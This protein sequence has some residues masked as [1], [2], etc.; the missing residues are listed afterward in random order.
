MAVGL[1]LSSGDFFLNAYSTVYA[2]IREIP[3]EENPGA[4][5]WFI[6]VFPGNK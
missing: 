2:E 6:N 3:P 1:G 4:S 5:V